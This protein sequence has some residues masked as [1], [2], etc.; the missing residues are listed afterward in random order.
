MRGRMRRCA[1]PRP[2]LAGRPDRLD[3]AGAASR[4]AR[5][6]GALQECPRESERHQAWISP[7]CIEAFVL[8]PHGPRA[9]FQLSSRARSE[10]SVRAVQPKKSTVGGRYRA[11]PNT[12]SDRVYRALEPRQSCFHKYIDYGHRYVE[13]RKCVGTLLGH[14]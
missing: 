12:S 6:R 7:G 4:I 10:A 11:C 5:C 9:E 8:G 1:L 3:T 13:H 2:L 14:V